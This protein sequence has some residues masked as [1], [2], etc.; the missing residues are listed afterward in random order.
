MCLKPFPFFQV[1]R[2]GDCALAILGLRGA[3]LL[4]LDEPTNHLD[5]PSQEILQTMLSDF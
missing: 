1:E 3:N 5:L 2:G 4:L